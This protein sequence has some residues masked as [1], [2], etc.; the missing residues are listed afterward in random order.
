MEYDDYLL[1]SSDGNDSETMLD[2]HEED[3]ERLQIWLDEE[4]TAGQGTCLTAGEGDDSVRVE[5]LRIEP[6]ADYTIDGPDDIRIVLRCSIG[7]APSVVESEISYVCAIEVT[8]AIK[9]GL[10]PELI[11][12][13]VLGLLWERSN[14]LR[15]ELWS[16]KVKQ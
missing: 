5:L 12:H 6:V 2:D 4:L 13:L 16:S 15:R 1:N 11:Q 9:E 3:L 14:G 7:D 10:V 8:T